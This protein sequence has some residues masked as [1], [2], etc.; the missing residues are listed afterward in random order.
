MRIAGTLGR[1]EHRCKVG[2]SEL[3]LLPFRSAHGNRPACIRK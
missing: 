1:E 2:E 3:V